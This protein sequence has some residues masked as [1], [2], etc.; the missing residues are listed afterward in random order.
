MAVSSTARGLSKCV[1]SQNM[2][3]SVSFKQGKWEVKV[4]FKAML[5]STWSV[6]AGDFKLGDP[7]ACSYGLS[8][9]V[10]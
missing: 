8:V 3:S 5:T 10:G 1:S 6:P 4:T 9:P 2:L 7:L